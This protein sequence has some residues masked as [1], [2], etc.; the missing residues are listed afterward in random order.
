MPTIKSFME[1]YDAYKVLK[2]FEDFIARIGKKKPSEQLELIRAH[3]VPCIGSEKT[4]LVN[5]FSEYLTTNVAGYK[6]KTL[7]EASNILLAEATKKNIVFAYGRMNPPTQM[8]G[9]LIDK[10]IQE[11]KKNN[12]EPRLYL[13]LTQD[14]D[15]NPLSPKDKQ[16]Y[17][18]SVYRGLEVRIDA[19]NA[20]DVM[21][22]LSKEGNISHVVL[23]TGSDQLSGYKSIQKYIDNGQY[24]VDSFEAKSIGERDESADGP[25]GVSA[26][27]V[28][29]MIREGA[30]IKN[31]KALLLQGLSDK[32]IQEIIGAIKADG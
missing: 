10:L 4:D 11:A 19:K 8:H 29:K 18:K 3:L 15:K 17:I 32:Y 27:K 5:L 24:K 13:S 16:K 31:I 6:R 20:F 23:M 30:D 25:A 1:K 7:S 2:D 22:Q 21:D 9:V 28:R 12:A 26:S 14:K